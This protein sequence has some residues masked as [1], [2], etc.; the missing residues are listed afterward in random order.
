MPALAPRRRFVWDAVGNV[1]VIRFTLKS[2]CE[3]EDIPSIFQELDRLVAEES[4]HNLI[5]DF[6]NVQKIASYAICRL[7]RLLHT[8]ESVNG[9]LV[10]CSLTPIIEEILTI[11]A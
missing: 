9:R 8:I 3:D 7:V 4:R 10:L 1:T 2:I 6:S 5:L 11:M